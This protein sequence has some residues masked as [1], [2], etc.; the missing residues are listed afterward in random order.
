MFGGSIDSWQANGECCIL[1][2]EGA[3]TWENVPKEVVAMDLFLLV[4]NEFVPIAL[5]NFE[6]YCKVIFNM[7][8]FKQSRT[9]LHTCDVHRRTIKSLGS[10]TE[11]EEV[12]H[13]YSG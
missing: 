8:V 12:T 5:D 2:R 10:L 13:T 7:K 11:H 4:E 1:C 3:D 9:T 6:M